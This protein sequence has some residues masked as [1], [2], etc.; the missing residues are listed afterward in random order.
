MY[1][2]DGRCTREAFACAA[3]SI[4][5][6]HRCGAQAGRRIRA[7][8]KEYVTFVRILTLIC[9]FASISAGKAAIFVT[10]YRGATLNHQG[11]IRCDAARQIKNRRASPRACAA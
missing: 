6:A 8:E 9:R 1:F 2:D 5:D 10:L 3:R 11:V 4:R 7:K